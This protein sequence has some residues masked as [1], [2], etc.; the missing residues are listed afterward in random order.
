L[1]CVLLPP[2]S[3]ALRGGESRLDVSS[4]LAPKTGP[5]FAAVDEKRGRILHPAVLTD[6]P[7]LDDTR[8]QVLALAVGVDKGH[9]AFPP[10]A[11]RS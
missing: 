9:P 4:S 2:S 5:H 11:L 3:G 7:L 1:E 6:L 10:D 8:L